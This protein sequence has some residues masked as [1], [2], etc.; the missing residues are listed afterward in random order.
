MDAAAGAALAAEGVEQG[1]GRGLRREGQFAVCHCGFESVGIGGQ[2]GI[3]VFAVEGVALGFGEGDELEDPGAIEV[4]EPGKHLRVKGANMHQEDIRNVAVVE[5]VGKLAI[6]TDVRVRGGE[7]AA[8]K[9]RDGRVV[10]FGFAAS[11]RIVP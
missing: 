9:L 5:S 6:K 11:I 10:A 7:V 3:D 4:Q 8:L 2:M 1:G